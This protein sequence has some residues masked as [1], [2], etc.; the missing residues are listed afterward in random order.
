MI[1]DLRRLAMGQT[2]NEA[3]LTNI[4]E[5][6]LLSDAIKSVAFREKDR[7]VLQDAIRQDIHRE[8]WDSA[9]LLILELEGGVGFLKNVFDDLELLKVA[10]EVGKH[11][12]DDTDDDGSADKGEETVDSA[13]KDDVSK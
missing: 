3:L 8:K 4:S 6:L 7:S 2:K 13:S 12:K 9:Q 10:K 5:N 11:G 1:T